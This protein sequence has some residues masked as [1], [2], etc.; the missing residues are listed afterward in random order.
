[1]IKK[2]RYILMLVILFSSAIGAQAQIPMPEKVCI[3]AVRHYWVDGMAG[4]SYTWKINGV[5]QSS[6]INQIDITWSTTGKFNLEVQEHQASCSGKIQSGVVEVTDQVIPV[7]VQIP[8][9]C[10]GSPVI[11]LP[12]TSQNGVTGTWIPAFVATNTIGTTTYTFTP[13]AGQCGIETTM[14]IESTNSVVP[15]FASIGPLCQNCASPVLPL[16][17]TNG[18][19]GTWNL[20]TVATNIVGISTYTFTPTTGQ[21]AGS[22][23]LNIETASPVI[24]DETHIDIDNVNTSGSIDLTVAGGTGPGTYLYSW[25]SGATT[26]DLTNLAIG[27]YKVIVT[28]KNGCQSAITVRILNVS[29]HA[30]VATFDEFIT[31]CSIIRGDL[32]HADNGHGKDYDPDGDTFFIDTTPIVGLYGLIL[33]SD[34]SFIFQAVPGSKGDVS[35]RYR[36]FDVKQ[37]FSIPATV[38]IHII[39]DRDHDG[40]ADADDMDADGDGILNIY[41]VITGEDWRTAD[42]DGDGLPNYLDIDADG[43][44]IVDNVETQSTAGYR[45]PVVYDANGN[46]IND[47]FDLRQSGYEIH[48]I[49]TDGDGIPDFLDMDSDND[50][51]PDMIEGHDSNSDG[52]ADFHSIGQDLDCDGLDD[53]YDSVFN[54]CHVLSNEVGSYAPML[55]FDGDGL[56]DWRDA[57]DD[58]DAYLTRNEDLNADGD[59]SNDDIDFDGSP[60]YLDYGPDCDLFIPEAFSPNGDNVHDYYQLYCINN[61]PNARIYIF[62]QQGNKI[63]EKAHYGNLEFWKTNASAW[64]AGNPDSGSAKAKHEMVAPG[65]YYYVLDLGNGEVK[66]S[67]VYVSY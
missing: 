64:W 66:K 54:D 9:M 62:D 42:R 7:F 14:D 30:P 1:M 43:D 61:Y 35:F 56:P 67:F 46:G 59:F 34:G 31:C 37:N 53:G 28:D 44:G 15:V 57:N 41:E 36:I 12:A 49:D 40:I 27:T 10:S 65:T 38:I 6:T 25:S 51:I 22:T 17:S 23:N 32:L 18:I 58:D 19:S 45:P 60:E 39:S 52:K 16:T 5:F 21:C 48:P 33:N 50:G 29:G 20:A 2:V 11:D 4:S 13:T 24:I 63:F 26:E 55:D 3:G 8:T 47:A